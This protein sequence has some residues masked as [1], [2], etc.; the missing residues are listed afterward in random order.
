M[1][2]CI[3]QLNEWITTLRVVGVLPPSHKASPAFLSLLNEIGLT[4]ECSASPKSMSTG[5][6][7]LKPKE[8]NTVLELCN[9]QQLFPHE[10]ES[11]MVDNTVA[12]WNKLSLPGPCKPITWHCENTDLG[13]KKEGH[14]VCWISGSSEF[15][16][17]LAIEDFE[18][19]NFGKI[20]TLVSVHLEGK[21]LCFARVE[22]F[23]TLDYEFGDIWICERT[24]ERKTC[25][26]PLSSLSVPLI[27]ANNGK[28]VI[29]LN[30]HI[31]F[32]PIHARMLLDHIRPK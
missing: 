13:K 29:V 25:F 26:V 10:V 12:T 1:F 32:M 14:N 9:S 16:D 15:K 31:R 2:H 22:K 3:F 5:I 24:A 6:T 7:V 27:T 20:Q 23:R 17:H 28:K 4:Q 11:F 18:L 19:F 8:I 21:K 30:S